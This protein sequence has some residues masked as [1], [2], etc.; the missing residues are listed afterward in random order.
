MIR[1]KY[2][3]DILGKYI[4]H[5]LAKI[6]MFTLSVFITVFFFTEEKQKIS[7][8]RKFAEFE[9][10]FYDFPKKHVAIVDIFS[11]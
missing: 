10:V 6:K 7:T 9:I 4:M 5:E 2:E 8:R 11:F 1:A 3:E